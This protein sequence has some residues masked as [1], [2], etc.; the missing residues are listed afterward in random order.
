MAT[1]QVDDMDEVSNSRSIWSRPIGTE[2]FQM[3]L[4]P[5]EHSG[6]H[7]DQIAWFLSWIFTKDSGFVAANLHS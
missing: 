1:S 2:Y 7:G 3:G 6:D 5:S 4:V